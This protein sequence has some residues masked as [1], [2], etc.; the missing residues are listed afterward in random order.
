MRRF[1]TDVLSAKDIEFS[2]KAPTNDQRLKIDLETRREMHLMFKE[3]VNNCVRHSGC[4]KVEIRIAVDQQAIDVE[5]RDN[6]KG[7]DVNEHNIGNG[8]ASMRSRTESIGGSLN[9]S[10]SAEG[11][12]VRY[13][14]PNRSA[15][16]IMARIVPFR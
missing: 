8:L 12:V 9:I 7:F 13:S 15:S 1:A 4:S 11:T 3:A 10:S 14:V 5:I 6:G 2:F 16:G